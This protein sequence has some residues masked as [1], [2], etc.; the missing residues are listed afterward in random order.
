[1]PLSLYISQFF[2][3][4]RHWLFFGTIIIT[5]LVYYFSQFMSKAYTSSTSIYA[6][7][8]STVSLSENEQLSYFSINSTFDNLINLSKA[9]GTLEKVAFKLLAQSYIYGNEF[10]DEEQIK[11]SNYRAL[12]R[13][14]PEDVLKLIDKKS[15]SIT[16]KRLMAYYKKNRTNF[17]YRMI[18]GNN[19]FFSC[20]ALSKVD[21]KRLGSS[22]L[23][24]I[25]YTTSDP[26]IAESTVRFISEELM[27]AYE[28]LRFSASNDV[29]AYFEKELKK[30][31]AQLQAQEEEMKEF[32]MANGVINYE[33]QSKALANH[34]T[35]F[36]GKYESVLETYEATSASLKKLNQTL[37]IRAKLL[38]TNAEFM[39]ELDNVAKLSQ[40][41]MQKE[42]FNSTNRL[43]SDEQLRKD[44]DALG[45]AEKKISR[46]ADHIDVY[47]Y[48][49]EGI[50]MTQMALK[51]LDDLIENTKAKAQ[52]EV[53]KKW[54]DALVQQY[55]RFSPVGT[56]LGRYER[57][58]GI[59]EEQ[60]KLILHGLHLAKLQQKSIQLNTATLKVVTDPTYPF[61]G[62]NNRWLYIIG[63]FIGSFIFIT[64]IFL[65]IELLDRTL[66][67]ELRTNKL[68]K[69]SVLGAFTGLNN[70]KFRGY[71]KACNRK[72]TAYAANRLSV[73]LK[74]GETCIINLLSL[75]KGEG[76]SFFAS[77]LTEH[78]E[79][80]G[81][82][83]TNIKYG[84]DFDPNTK[85]Y[86]LAQELSEIWKPTSRTK[87]N[88]VLVEYPEMSTSN[89]PLSLLKE[90][91]I[92]LLICNACRLWKRNDDILLT[93]IKKELG[94]NNPQFYI[95]L[96]NADR[97][98]VENFTGDLPPQLPIHSFIKNLF[99]LG[100][101]AKKAAV[102]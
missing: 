64:G 91:K 102:K 55:T 84:E 54:K 63:A 65:I 5:A 42:I 25:S 35:D 96:N 40:D 23:I 89:A 11:A 10:Q 43:E 98:V 75:Q 78:W 100:F 93:Q 38:Q 30:I 68:T 95:Y 51:W 24:E 21:T 47:S 99:S 83:V 86:V 71:T 8:T 17:V 6:G 74:P 97:Y 7:V 19:E 88:I 41:I 34:A 76:K 31:K 52:L 39:S 1:M 15:M 50:N 73:F 62:S 69:T 45:E 2:Y 27:K 37:E 9:R 33:E 28:N 92:N 53:M 60:L 29:V 61:S 67:D 20:S 4:I 94:D 82:N 79:D 3:R 56:M 13:E 16:E 44:R 46:I 14:T 48:S 57:G 85:S 72:A 26:G 81:F 87:P 101:T 66:R 90:A 80:M 36:N 32:N 49:K 59:T 70:I 12:L 58:I 77:F 18:N 22:D